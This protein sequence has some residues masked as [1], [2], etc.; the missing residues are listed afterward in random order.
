MLNLF[1]GSQQLHPTKKRTASGSP[2]PAL[3][4]DRRL[5]CRADRAA[6]LA[7]AASM[8]R[9]LR[10]AKISIRA[11]SWLNWLYPINF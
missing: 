9:G 11:H 1:N 3:G 5:T 4:G 10:C 6:I 7:R 8:A 2:P